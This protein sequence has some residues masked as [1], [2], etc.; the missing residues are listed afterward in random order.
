MGEACF[1]STG[2]H[3]LFFIVTDMK[4][5]DIFS[6]YRRGWL[7]SQKERSRPYPAHDDDDTD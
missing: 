1:I 2:L 7:H 6:A 5:I 3:N 4:K